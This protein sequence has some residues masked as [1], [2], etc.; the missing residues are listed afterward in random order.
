MVR[1]S[2][3]TVASLVAL[4]ACGDPLIVLGDAPGRMRI[5]A[6]VGDS[7]GTR[8][9]TL[10]TRTRLTEPVAVAFDE[11]QAVLFAA[12]RG[13]V[14]QSGGSTRRMARLVSVRSNGRLTLVFS[15]ASCPAACPQAVHS[16]VVA[17][18]GAVLLTDGVA[19]RV[20]RLDA[21]A[22]LPAAIAGD[23]TAGDAPDGTLAANA[24]V[25]APSGIA[26]GD[27]GR[28]YFAEQGGH[29]IRVIEPDGRLRTVAGTGSPGAA[30]DGGPAAAA[31]LN[32]PAGIAVGGDVLYIADRLNH[33]IRAV[34]LTTGLITTLAGQGAAGFGGDG[35][36]ATE[37]RFDRPESV[38]LSTDQ[39]TV[40]IAD[41]G[42]HRIRAINLSSGIVQS[43]AGTGSVS[44]SGAGR[45]AGQ[46]SLELPS[47]VAAGLGFLFI[48]DT[49][50][51]VVWR[52]V[53]RL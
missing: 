38:A 41:Y 19:H 36:P 6:G 10:A 39:L 5:V 35:G 4:A 30:G 48:A 11:S 53:V 16:I 23:G 27:G 29:R 17:T 14:V 32:S 42:N 1:S 51:S 34:S 31:Q 28:I 20:Y 43:S 45:P 2:A 13:A 21:G 24:R 46:T 7:I 49:G 52:M 8:I 18:G 50:H 15:G 22:S 25:R 37:A 40:F 26:V 33:R 9:D 47:G 44:W 12:D 3:L